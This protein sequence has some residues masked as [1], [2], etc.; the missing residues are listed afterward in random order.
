M[1]PNLSQVYHR[2]ISGNPTEF[3]VRVLP[4]GVIVEDDM[5]IAYDAVN[6][7][8]LWHSCRD[9]PSAPLPDALV[10]TVT[11][12]GDGEASVSVRKTTSQ[13]NAKSQDTDRTRHTEYFLRLLP[14]GVC[15]NDAA[16]VRYDH[17]SKKYTCQRYSIDRS[18]PLPPPYVF[19]SEK[20]RDG[21][22]SF[23]GKITV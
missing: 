3:S 14:E 11:P 10:F 2:I 9:K 1:M 7:D 8:Y 6:K 4:E 19:T 21:E 5:V 18:R 12:Q 17:S 16:I 23:C 20:V 15:V 22:T 13:Q